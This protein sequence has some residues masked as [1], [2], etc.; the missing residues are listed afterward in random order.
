M[1]LQAEVQRLRREVGSLSK[2]TEAGDDERSSL[3]LA[4][5]DAQVRRKRF[6]ASFVLYVHRLK[7]VG[8]ANNSRTKLHMT[9]IRQCKQ[10][11]S[12]PRE[13]NNIHHCL[14]QHARHGLL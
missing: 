3:K 6:S 11:P 14:L 8:A 2:R 7:L 4:L 12:P 13:T 5:A 9:S 1:L 10:A